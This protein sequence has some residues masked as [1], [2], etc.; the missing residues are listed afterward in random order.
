MKRNVLSFDVAD[1]PIPEG[2]KVAEEIARN[3]RGLRWKRL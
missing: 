2:E 1:R 3:C